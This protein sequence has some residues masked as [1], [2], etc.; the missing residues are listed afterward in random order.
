MFPDVPKSRSEAALVAQTAK[1]FFT[2][3]NK[4]G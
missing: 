3:F 2:N 1:Y 4:V